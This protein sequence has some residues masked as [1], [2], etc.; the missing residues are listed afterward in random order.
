V[1]QPGQSGNPGGRPS[2]REHRAEARNVINRG[3]IQRA[4]ELARLSE[5]DFDKNGILK[6]LPKSADGGT[7][8][9]A[10]KWLALVGYGPPHSYGP[11][12]EPSRHW[13]A[14]HPELLTPAQRQFVQR[15]LELIRQASVQPG[16]AVEVRK[17]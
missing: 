4:A 2:L 12:E 16:D 14:F 1:W 17:P 15:A 7:I 11:P 8:L 9:S 3:G 10:L 5:R 6:P 13:G